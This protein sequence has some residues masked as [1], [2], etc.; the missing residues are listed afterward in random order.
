MFSL[1][2]LAFLL[3]I[4]SSIAFLVDNRI[5]EANKGI[6]KPSLA[7]TFV[8]TIKDHDCNCACHCA[9]PNEPNPVGAPPAPNKLFENRTLNS[10]EV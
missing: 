6:N 3:A 8:K 2:T 4:H 10:I 1:R 5:N 9:A 7:F